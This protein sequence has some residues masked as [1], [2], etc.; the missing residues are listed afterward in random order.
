[1]FVNNQKGS[2]GMFS[3]SG[4]QTLE[5]FQILLKKDEIINGNNKRIQ[6]NDLYSPEEFDY[7]ENQDE[8]FKVYS[9]EPK[10][11]LASSEIL[12]KK[13]NSKAASNNFNN[14]MNL[15]NKRNI[16]LITTSSNY[17]SNAERIKRDYELK[18]HINPSCTKYNPNWQYAKKKIVWGLKWDYNLGNYN[19]DYYN[20]NTLKLENN[21]NNNNNAKYTSKSNTTNLNKLDKYNQHKSTNYSIDNR[22]AKKSMNNT[23]N[24]YKNKNLEKSLI[25]NKNNKKRLSSIKTNN[26]LFYNNNNISYNNTEC[27]ISN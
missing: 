1:M 5:K 15:K 12:L 19:N 22:Q 20:N 17:L 2:H 27:K 6:T 11:K 18:K 8:E 16:K 3:K 21:N 4:R 14:N 9:Q 26:K 23:T 25:S 7:L 24:K 10:E 13:Y